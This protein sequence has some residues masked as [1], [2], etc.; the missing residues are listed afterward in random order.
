LWRACASLSS[1][2]QSSMRIQR[3]HTAHGIG[4]LFAFGFFL[5]GKF[6]PSLTHFK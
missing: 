6:Y 2:N 4:P 1:F 3:G 5:L